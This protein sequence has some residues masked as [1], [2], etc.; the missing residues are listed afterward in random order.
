VG[1]FGN[2]GNVQRM[3]ERLTSLGYQSEQIQG[4]QLTK[5]AIRTSCEKNQLQ[6]VLNEARTSINPESWIY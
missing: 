4:G 2:P 5:V 1:A 6:K 3:E